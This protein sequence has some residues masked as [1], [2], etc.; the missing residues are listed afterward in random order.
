MAA[1]AFE[2]ENRVDQ[3]LDGFGA[4]NLSVLGDM[5]DEQQCRAARLRIAHQI[6]GC[7]TYLR[8][9]AGR[10]FER[11][12]PDRLD[13]VD[14]DDA[15]RRLLLQRRQ[16]VF[17]IGGRAERHFRVRQSHARGAQA[18]LRHRLFAGDID[19]RAALVRVRR[20]RLKNERR[21]AD[22]RIAADEKRRARHQAAAG[23]AI[24]FRRAC[25]AARRR[26]V[27][28][29]QIFQ[30]EL[31]ATLARARI[32]AQRNGRALFRDRVPPAAGI[33]FARPFGRDVPAALAS[34][35]RRGLRHQPRTSILIGPS[36]RPWMNWSTYS[37]PELSMSF[38]GPCQMI[39]PL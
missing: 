31:A 26:F 2:I 34:E 12:G 22:A 13:G 16:N 25:D 38:V 27:F 21:F 29:L 39:L 24:E 30:R 8:D 18:H 15:G 7:G 17:D 6:E 4:C 33:A 3:M 5:A 23:D 14:G 28:G 35:G 1:L 20:E 11:G 9:G 19:G 36:A 10:G 32:V 37:L